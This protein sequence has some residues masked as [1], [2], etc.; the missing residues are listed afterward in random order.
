MRYHV[1]FLTFILSIFSLQTTPLFA[2]SSQVLDYELN[3]SIYNLLDVQDVNR[4]ITENPE[5][6]IMDEDMI[7]PRTPR[8]VIVADGGGGA[9]Y[10]SLTSFNLSSCAIYNRTTL[11][12]HHSSYVTRC[13]AANQSYSIQVDYLSCALFGYYNTALEF[14]RNVM[15]SG[16]W[17][18][19]RLFS[20]YNVVVNVKIDGITYSLTAE[21]IGNIHY[22]YVGSVLFSEQTLKKAA[23]VIQATQNYKNI[24]TW[25]NHQ[26]FF[27][28]PNDQIAI[29]R[30]IDWYR[31]GYF[32]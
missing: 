17:D 26:S 19:K 8:M 30:G 24:A 1:L 22:G 28:D 15:P 27:D 25:L 9:C 23:G 16:A 4:M 11:Q 12:N 3:G 2:E 14:S 31:N 20:S 29:Q 13:L 32:R 18:Y 10:D 7:I 21:S 6:M 5:S